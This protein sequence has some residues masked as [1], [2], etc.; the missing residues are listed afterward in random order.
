MMSIRSFILRFKRLGGL[1]VFI[2]CLML[3]ETVLEYL[4]VV[5]DGFTE[6][7]MTDFYEMEENI[8]NIY[9]GSSHVHYNIQPE[10]L[11]EIT[12]ENNFNLSTG[13]QPMNA[14]Y[15]LLREADKRQKL[16]HVYLEIS[17][18]LVTGDYGK[19]TDYT[20]L[21]NNW[22]VL[23]YVKPS[24]NK[25]EWMLSASE[26]QYYYLTFIPSIRYHKEFLDGKHMANRLKEKLAD[27]NTTWNGGYVYKGYRDDRTT[28]DGMYLKNKE[29][30]ILGN[31]PISQEVIIYMDK[32]MKY[33]HDNGIEL[34]IFT[35]PIADCEMLNIKDYDNFLF[36]MREIV[37]E[38]QVP[39]YDF[40][41]CK[42]EY[43]NLQ[44]EKL[45]RDTNHLNFW[46]A[47]IFTHF[48]G[49]VNES[50][51]KGEDVTKFFF[52]S[53]GQ[54]KE[55][56]S[57]LGGLRV[58]T[59]A[60]DSDEVTVSVDTIDN[61]KDKREV[62]YKVYLLDE[63]E[64]EESLIQDWGTQNIFVLNKKNGA[65]YAEIQARSGENIIKCKIALMD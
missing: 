64:N 3:T 38:Y 62:E 26:P 48:L 57:F 21:P 36:Q 44:D 11:D 18:G 63:E 47:E 7:L 41:L 10:I 2:A 58:M 22:R 5:R 53:Y 32:I 30:I 54:K 4:L 43:L 56:S 23:N 27:K 51:K 1:L 46:G 12:G 16:S 14:S 39:Y 61:F 13:L 25:L 59:L 45:W 28:I 52:D 42:S 49:E 19:I 31:N 24:F 15:Y 17:V 34:T 20:Q 55:M 6:L 37:S 50:A 8:D 35:S 60:D 29:E 33:C 40:N 65:E 9:L